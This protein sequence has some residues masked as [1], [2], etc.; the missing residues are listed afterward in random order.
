LPLSV[1][2]AVASPGRDSLSPTV[3]WAA[4]LL[5]ALPLGGWAALRAYRRRP[6]GVL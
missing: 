5:F 2:L 3:W 1:A 6:L 4:T